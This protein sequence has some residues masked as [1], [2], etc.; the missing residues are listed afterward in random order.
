ML[1]GRS[2]FSGN[3]LVVF[4]PLFVCLKTCIVVLDVCSAK[5]DVNIYILHAGETA[6][7]ISVH[8]GHPLFFVHWSSRVNVCLCVRVWNLRDT[9]HWWDETSLKSC[10]AASPTAVLS[11][12]TTYTGQGHNTLCPLQ[13]SVTPPVIRWVTCQSECSN[14][15]RGAQAKGTVSCVHN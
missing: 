4:L 14:V 10:G 12:L 15:L 9:C 8:M 6:T 11:S 7:D 1:E 3:L 13:Y 2:F 5:I